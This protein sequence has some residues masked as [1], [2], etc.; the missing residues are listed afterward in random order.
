MCESTGVFI[1]VVNGETW[2]EFTVNPF[3][4]ETLEFQGIVSLGSISTLLKLNK[5]SVC[6]NR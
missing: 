1:V 4:N 2:L 6:G 3:S 5:D